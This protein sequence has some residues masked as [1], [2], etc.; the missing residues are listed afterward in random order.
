VKS[1]RRHQKGHVFRKGNSWFLRYYDYRLQS[2]GKM[3][4]V[5]KCRK[6]VGYGGEYRSK[7][8]VQVLADEF[9]AP[10]NNGTMTPHSTMKLA[11][12]V[13]SSYLPFVM[14]TKRPST[15]KGY[16]NMWKRYLESR[17]AIALRDFRTVDGERLLEDIAYDHS[18]TGTTL[19]HIKAFLSGVFR[20]AKR[21]GVLNSEN[22]M[23]DVVLPKGKPAGETYAYSLAE[24]TRMLNQLTEPAATVVA[25]AAF[26][27]VREGELRG[28]LW[29]NYDGE[30]IRI[31]QSVWRKHIQEPKTKKSASP[32]PIIPRLSER[33]NQHRRLMGNP[34]SGLVF[35]NSVG[36]PMCMARLAR[37][38]IRPAF[39]KAGIPWHGW[40]AFRRGLA[41]NLHHLGVPDKTIQAILRHSNVAVT[42]ACYIKTI[43]ADAVEAMLSLEHATNVQHEEVQHVD[44]GEVGSDSGGA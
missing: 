16:V 41:T 18:L 15:Y 11:Q 21:K 28:L 35:P 32:V 43:S 29:E 26:T 3:K 17:S 4:L 22:P 9:L 27:G 36:K 39:L 6:L 12:F 7:K 23:R 24:I 44:S 30:Q 2:D 10:I 8:A 31:T 38:V 34:T 13:E 33:L 14:A 40:H 1:S 42:Q 37:D 5:S 20:F 25:T 19:A